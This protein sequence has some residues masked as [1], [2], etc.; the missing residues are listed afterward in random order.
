[1]KLWGRAA[2]GNLSIPRFRL[3]KKG[4]SRPF[5]LVDPFASQEMGVHTWLQPFHTQIMPVKEGVKR[6]WE[7]LEPFAR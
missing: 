3:E 4:V 2:R 1:M 7:S 5:K 6:S